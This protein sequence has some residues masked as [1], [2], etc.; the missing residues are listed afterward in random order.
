M[1]PVR[2]YRSWTAFTIIELVVVMSI[3]MVLGTIGVMS[4]GSYIQ[5]ANDAKRVG[6]IAL[7][8]GL[9]LKHPKGIHSDLYPIPQISTK[10]M[11]GSQLV[12]YQAF[13]D[14]FLTSLVGITKVPTDPKANTPYLYSVSADGTSYQVAA[15]LE[16]G[17]NMVSYSP[18]Y[19][20]YADSTN[21]NAAVAIVQGTFVSPNKN[22]LPGLVYV[23]DSGSA[24]TP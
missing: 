24:F 20:V 16:N 13:F 11:T 21:T 14:G 19:H 22:I 8:P 4:F 5:N 18:T 15:T 1:S 9:A 6:D 7:I 10:I 17:S 23:T 12:A 2:P 3:L